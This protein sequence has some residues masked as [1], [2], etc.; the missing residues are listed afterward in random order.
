M[1]PRARVKPEWNSKA[2]VPFITCVYHSHA[3][4]AEEREISCPQRGLSPSGGA[5]ASPQEFITEFIQALNE[6]IS[7]S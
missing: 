6:H 2:Y 5:L 3:G 4:D 1:I 7:L